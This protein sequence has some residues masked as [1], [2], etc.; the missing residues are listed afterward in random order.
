M[1]IPKP[2]PGYQL[3]QADNVPEQQVI[4]PRELFKAYADAPDGITKNKY[5][6]YPTHDID[7][8]TN[9][10]IRMVKAGW[11]I[12]AAFHVMENNQSFRIDRPAKN[13]SVI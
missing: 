5:I 11:K 13:A 6:V 10:L 12:R 1:Q 4:E 8:S 7:H 9:L 2:P 3:S